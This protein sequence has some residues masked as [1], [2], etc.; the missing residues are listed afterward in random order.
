ME[1]YTDI[2]FYKGIELLWTI[3]LDLS[4]I[5]FWKGDIEVIICVSGHGGGLR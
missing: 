1:A 5:L 3:N 4:Y 2:H